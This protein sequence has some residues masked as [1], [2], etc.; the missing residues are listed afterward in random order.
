MI[1][2]KSKNCEIIN[3]SDF[4][5]NSVISLLDNFVSFAEKKLPMDLPIRIIFISN[6]KESGPLA[7]TGKYV[8]G[9]STI[10]VYVDGRHAK[11]ILRSISHEMIHH[12]QNKLGHFE[13]A[14][15][16]L[17][18]AQNDIGLRNAEMQAYLLGNLIFRDWEDGIKN[19]LYSNRFK[20][21]NEFIKKV[22]IQ[23]KE[24]KNK[25]PDVDEEKKNEENEKLENEASISANVAGYTLPLGASNFSSSR[26][27]KKSFP[28]GWKRLK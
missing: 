24:K 8:P 18:Y 7:S 10:I 14:K 26:K 4:D 11:D 15:T 5:V 16:G 19:V 23:E 28:T 3:K 12:Y 2:I 17:G 13:G 20:K 27:E 6:K 22:A 1:K 21:I 25:H 9:N